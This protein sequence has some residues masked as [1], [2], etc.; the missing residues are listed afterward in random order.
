MG[1]S[2]VATRD[3]PAGTVLRKS[4]IAMKSPANGLDPSHFDDLIG[5]KIC[6]PLKQDECLSFDAL[7][8]TGG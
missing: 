6:R 3:L 5:K 4:D 1:K 2:L 8:Q 7:E